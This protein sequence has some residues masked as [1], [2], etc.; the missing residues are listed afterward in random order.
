MFYS[1]ESK[2][3]QVEHVRAFNYG[4][5]WMVL[6]IFYTWQFLLLLSM[7]SLPSGQRFPP[8]SGST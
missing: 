8:L 5:G 1:H 2:L 4:L 3:V 6:I 7:A